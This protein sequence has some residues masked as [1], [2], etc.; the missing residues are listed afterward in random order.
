MYFDCDGV[1]LYYEI[2]GDPNGKETIAFFNGVMASTNSWDL[3]VPTLTKFGFKIIC[4]DFKGQ[5]KSDKPIPQNGEGIYS[6]AEHA[7]E[8]KKLLEHL[9]IDSV[10]ICGTSYGGEVGMKFAS[11]FPEMVKT[12]TVIDSVSELD[13]V[14]KSFVVGWKALCD[15][16]DGETFFWGMAPSI[17]GGDFMRDNMDMLQKRGK[18]FK[19]VDNSYFVGQK[20]LYDTFAKDVYMTNELN[21]IQCP[22]LVICGQEDILKPQK[23]SDIMYNNIK[24]CEFVTLPHCGHV[25]IFEKPKELNS[26]LLGFI[27]KNMK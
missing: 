25:T 16:G 7:N 4:H 26:L 13:E 11:M 1:K 6:F 27:L 18:A 5:M 17:Y 21:K 9:G 23:F 22:T 10:H 19:N 20:I 14:C 12:L 24:N 3:L 15:I 8:A 2:K